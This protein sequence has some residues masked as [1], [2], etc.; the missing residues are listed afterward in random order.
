MTFAVCALAGLGALCALPVQAQW[1]DNKTPG[2]PRTAEG[3]PDLSAPLPRTTD[4][5]PDLTGIWR[6][7]SSTQEPPKLQPWAEA[8]AKNRM[9]D[10]RRDSP[11]TLC[12]PGPIASLGV[13]K[14]VQTP[15]L[16]L[17]LYGGTLY[18]EIF[19]DGREL[20]KDPNPDWMGYSIG[21]WDDDTLIVESIG[22]NDRTWLRGNGVPGTERLHINER[23]RRSNFGHMEV[24]TTYGVP[25]SGHICSPARLSFDMSSDQI[26]N[27][28]N[29]NCYFCVRT[30][31][32]PKELCQSTDSTMHSEMPADKHSKAQAK[33][34]DACIF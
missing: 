29:L 19:L 21:R 3:N 25:P 27:Q 32:H 1:L 13:G 34:I 16:L 7:E 18:R 23:I 24:R 33:C 2:I 20:P 9:E 4:G 22:F 30:R 17:M 15:G 31:R 14:V 12:L 26:R 10:L 28:I 6:T 5:K 8:V 11:E